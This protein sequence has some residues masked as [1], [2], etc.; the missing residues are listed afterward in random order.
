MGMGGNGGDVDQHHRQTDAVDVPPESPWKTYTT[1]SPVKDADTDSWPALSEAKQRPKITAN[2][3]SDSVQSPPPQ[4]AVG[5]GFDATQ[6]KV[7]QLKTNGRGNFKYPR[8]PHGIYHNKTGPKLGSSGAPPIPIRTPAPK[9]IYYHPTVP[10]V[11]NAMLPMP[12]ISGCG[13]AHPVSHGS[14][15]GADTQVL[16]SGSDAPAQEFVPPVNGVFY[17]SPHIDSSANYSN[18]VRRSPGVKNRG[19]QMNPSWNNQRPVAYYDTHLQ[20]N[21]GPRPFVSPPFF[22]PSGLVDGPYLA[23]R[24]GFISFFPTAPPPGYVRIPYQPHLV[25]YPVKPGVPMP[26]TP[27]MSSRARIVTQIEYY[28]S[29]KNLQSDH[30]LISLMD[31]EGWVPISTIAEFPR[32]KIMNAEIPFIL[33]ALLSSET[34]EVQGE[35]IRRQN[36][37]SKW[38]PSTA[39]SKSSPPVSTASKNDD[40]NDSKTDSFEETEEFHA[41]NKSSGDYLSISADSKKESVVADARQHGDKPFVSGETLNITS[42]N[43][44]LRMALDLNPDNKNSCTENNN[45]PK[46]EIPVLMNQDV[47]DIDGSA[48]DFSSTLILDKALELELKMARDCHNLTLGRSEDDNDFND[49]VIER[50]VIVTQNNRTSEV[51]GEESKTMSSELASAINDSLYFYEQ[52]INSKLSP[53][54]DSKTCNETC[55][56]NSIYPRNDFPLN[57]KAPDCSTREIDCEC[58]CLVNFN[59]QW[60]QN[61]D[62]FKPHSL[63]KQRLF[64][65]NFR[66]QGSDQNSLGIVSESP[67]SNSIGFYFCP[68]PDTNGLRDSKLCASPCKKLSGTSPPVGYV[69]KSFPPFR[70]PN[71][72][73]LEENHFKQQIYKEYHQCC[74]GE[75]KNLGIGCSEKMNTLYRFWSYFLRDRF[76]PSMYNEF[77]TIALEDAAAGCNYGIECLFRFYRFS[78]RAAICCFSYGLKNVFREHLYESFEQLT[79][80]FYK[81]GNLYG[82]QKYWEFHH[83]RKD[84]GQT[85]PLKKHPELERLLRD[86]YRTLDDFPR[87]EDQSAVLES[88]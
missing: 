5:D 72:R 52:E 43:S 18:S 3:C 33:D 73:L 56:E 13:Y 63:Q 50:L 30:Y 26:P 32:I 19:G 39:I 20:Q 22:G 75:R 31:G 68:P 69:P 49:Q 53:H 65:G 10:P 35:K 76:I 40:L 47:D 82:F 21:M 66:S 25:P 29:D 77:R 23:G 54:W 48:N 38:A 2:M 7:D 11:F 85:E 71:Y 8:K 44:N 55:D 4:Q 34:I 51:P 80:D 64:P 78:W 36:T 28:F 9:P 59:S 60:K 81:K 58:P 15:P 70:H 83:F 16:K 27:T 61:E 67:P 41:P 79:F 62:C 86:E 17:P 42:G 88:C 6:A 12:P 87:P 46:K 1:A 45:D 24:P 14:F 84:H 57:S 37:W 74:L